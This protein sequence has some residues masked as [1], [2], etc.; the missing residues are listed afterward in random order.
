MAWIGAVGSG[1]IHSGVDQSRGFRS[2]SIRGDRTGLIHAIDP[3]P[4]GSIQGGAFRDEIRLYSLGGAG[5][6][7]EI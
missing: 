5:T 4:A 6:Q 2:G 1:L 3:R 7:P